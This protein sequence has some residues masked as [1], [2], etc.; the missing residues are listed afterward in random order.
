MNL[1]TESLID[2][3]CSLPGHFDPSVAASQLLF[4]PAFDCCTNLQ[5]VLMSVSGIE[6]QPKGFYFCSIYAFCHGIG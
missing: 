6:N 3:A 5:L 2:L 1:F 4:S